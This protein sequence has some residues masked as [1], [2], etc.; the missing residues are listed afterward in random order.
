[1]ADEEEGWEEGGWITETVP[2]VV[3]DKQRIKLGHRNTKASRDLAGSLLDGTVEAPPE[4]DGSAVENQLAK[5]ENEPGM[6]RI[7]HHKAMLQAMMDDLQGLLPKMVQV[8][9]N[10]DEGSKGAYALATI[11]NT[12]QSLVSDLADH[13]DPDEKYR[14]IEKEVEQPMMQNFISALANEMESAKIKIERVT[15]PESHRAINEAFRG[16]VTGAGQKCII[17]YNGSMTVLRR[18]LGST[19]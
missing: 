9:K 18:I 15:P 6:D 17:N 4:S 10:S 13:D 11:I 1:M 14:I 16:A 3:M 5:R 7:D 8:T 12:I 19:K 2:E